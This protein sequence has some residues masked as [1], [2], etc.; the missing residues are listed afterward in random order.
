MASTRQHEED[1]VNKVFE[2]SPPFTLKIDTISC[3]SAMFAASSL[4]N[5]SGAALPDNALFHVLLSDREQHHAHWPGDFNSK[6][7]IDY[8]RRPKGPPVVMKDGVAWVPIYGSYYALAGANSG[9]PSH[10]LNRKAWPWADKAYKEAEMWLGLLMPS[11]TMMA[12]SRSYRLDDLT[13]IQKSHFRWPDNM[14]MANHNLN[15]PD[16]LVHHNHSDSY[17]DGFS[18]DTYYHLVIN[19]SPDSIATTAPPAPPPPPQRKQ[20]RLHPLIIT[21]STYNSSD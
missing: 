12:A 17:Y 11:K 1:E 4:R 21:S 14:R 9:L 10:L 6:S 20:K 15:F 5:S 16:N 7:V 18:I 8:R 19:N 13:A 2:P 3:K